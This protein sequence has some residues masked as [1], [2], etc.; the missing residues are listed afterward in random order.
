ML[1]LLSFFFAACFILLKNW[2]CGNAESRP[3][4]VVV[5]AVSPASPHGWDPGRGNSESRQGGSCWLNLWPRLGGCRGSRSPW[6]SAAFG[7]GRLPNAGGG[8]RDR[9][10]GQPGCSQDNVPC[11]PLR[12]EVDLLMARAFILSAQHRNAVVSTSFCQTTRKT[13]GPVLALSRR[14]SPTR[15]TPSPE[16]REPPHTPGFAGEKRI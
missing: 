6:G 15:P 8:M 11:P 1:Q 5:M 10:G 3:V 4:A 12:T 9:P 2:L 13:L 16:P 7:T 14:H